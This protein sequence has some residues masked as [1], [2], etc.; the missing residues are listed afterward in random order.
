MS[1]LL[2]SVVNLFLAV[3]NTVFRGLLIKV[4]WGWFVLSQFPGLPKLEVLGAIGL[5]F[6]IGA[7]APWKNAISQEIENMKEETTEHR[8]MVQLI[9][10][11]GTTFAI[12]L[13]FF[14]GWV[15]HLFF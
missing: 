12:C 11:A 3:W 4:F 2:L 13:F 8:V 9:N 14:C 7:F 10:G 5:S 1:T 15:L 6:V